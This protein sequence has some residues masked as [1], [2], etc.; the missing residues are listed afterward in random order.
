[1]TLRQALSSAN[2][3][4]RI[5]SARARLD[6]QDKAVDSHAQRLAKQADRLDRLAAR[7]KLLRSDF[8]RIEHQ[9]GALE[10]KVERVARE[11]EAAP[12]T[13]DPDDIADAR[14][15]VEQVQREHEQIRV[16]FQVIT[17]YEERLRRV[18]ELLDGQEG[19]EG[20]PPR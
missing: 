17:R 1:M 7:A 12:V 10:E 8:E 20:S 15:V 9:L 5:D 2:P 14:T 4:R 19:T 13:A 3:K 16:R 6:R 18:E 11:R